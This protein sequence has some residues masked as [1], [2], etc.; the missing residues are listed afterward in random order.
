VSDW[1]YIAIA[2]TVVWGSLA[3][4]ALLLARRVTQARNVDRVL[5]DAAQA[6]ADGNRQDDALCD[7]PPAP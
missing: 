7:A 6:E 2:Y 3:V 4:Y 1:A 5:R